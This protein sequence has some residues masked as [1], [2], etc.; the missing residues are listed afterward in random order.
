MKHEVRAI[1]VNVSAMIDWL[2]SAAEDPDVRSMD[3]ARHAAKLTALIGEAA[4][5][6]AIW[7]NRADGSFV[8]SMPEAGLLNAKGREW[9]KR[10]MEGRAYTSDIYISAI[11][12]RPCLTI[13]MPI[14]S[15]GDR[16]AGV[17]GIDLRM[18]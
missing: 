8:F 3:E 18:K 13:A 9:W 11:T 7:S 4:E 14:P 16:P 10:A 17:I 1:D 15:D 5:V 6:E 2:S 12:K